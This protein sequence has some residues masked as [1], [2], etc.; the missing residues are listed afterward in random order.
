MDDI[1]RAQMLEGVYRKHALAAHAAQRKSC[2]TEV[3]D[4]EECGDPIPEAR[5]KASPG[6]VYCVECQRELRP[7]RKTFLP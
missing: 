5:R 1:E 4:C 3:L 6:C 7:R 2:M